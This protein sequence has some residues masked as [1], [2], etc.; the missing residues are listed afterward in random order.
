MRV[1]GKQMK[2]I[3]VCY[4]CGFPLLWT[5]LYDDAEYYCL[6]CGSCTGMLGGS[7]DV[8]E[9]KEL[10]AQYIVAEKVF[11]ALKP[12]LIGVGCY[13]KDKCKKCKEGKDEYHT[14][15]LTELEKEK[16][17]IADEMLKDLIKN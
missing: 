17:K 16:N 11:E 8:E 1:K 9:T 5:F 3:K 7:K 6:R 12:F 2:K 15:H 4:N 14:Q 13:K 10:R